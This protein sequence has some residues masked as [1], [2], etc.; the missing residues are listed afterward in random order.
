MKKRFY[1]TAVS[2][3]VMAALAAP[4]SAVDG[5]NY[6]GA[7]ARNGALQTNYSALK[8]S[9]N[10]WVNPAYVIEYKNR[11]DVNMD[12]WTGGEA[13][14]VLKE[15]NGSTYGIYLGRPSES[16][17]AQ[18]TN[19]GTLQYGNLYS[20]TV[21]GGNRGS[22]A[23]ADWSGS[24]A[25]GSFAAADGAPH[26]EAPT[27]Q[28]DLFWG[29]PLA[30]GKKLGVR[31]NYQAIET[32]D[33]R[34]KQTLKYSDAG[35]TARV[36]DQ[37]TDTFRRDD[38]LLSDKVA[39]S[40]SE[41]NI[42]VGVEAAG[43]D[44]ALLLGMP[45]SGA[46]SAY[47]DQ[48]KDVT[49]VA[50]AVTSTTITSFDG[51]KSYSGESAQ[52]TGLALRKS[53]GNGWM[54]ALMYQTYSSGGTTSRTDSTN[55]QVA[56]GAGTLTTH[57]TAANS[58]LE[59]DSAEL[60][61]TQLQFTKMIQASADTLV[62][63]S[64]GFM[65]TSSD[66]TTSTDYLV[67]TNTDHLT[68][69]TTF[70]AVNYGKTAKVVSS[71]SETTLPL[72]LA[73]ESKLSKKWT[74]RGSVNKNLYRAREESVAISTFGQREDVV[75]VN[76]VQQYNI[77]TT[78]SKDSATRVWDTTTNVAIGAGYTVD[79]LTVDAVINKTFVTNDITDPLTA[80]LNVTWLF[81]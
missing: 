4:A 46:S 16:T 65:S 9:Y 28:F 10:I 47:S 52:N 50:G 71:S 11:A 66:E 55:I 57:T 59:E 12:T 6:S 39:T 20:A 42:S 72:V 40:S 79:N 13:V 37:T 23:A 5:W 54:A 58:Y 62:A 3:A 56:D 33:S 67:T 27:N 17:L 7:N 49:L 68:N 15:H 43:W 45:D 19:D 41:M 8:D 77:E 22:L 63:A 74:V 29:K 73:A 75:L 1:L 69:T 81:D 25:T 36:I 35:V 24:A 70:S 30:G 31:F 76:T 64:V 21:V 48:Q 34:G 80:G 53:I 60:G 38:T 2:A 18:A 61:S 26:V 44:V 14:G 78:V 32:T 51:S